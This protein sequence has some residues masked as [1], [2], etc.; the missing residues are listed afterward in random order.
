MNTTTVDTQVIVAGSGGRSTPVKLTLQ[1]GTERVTVEMKVVTTRAVTTHGVTHTPFRPE[2]TQFWAFSAD[3]ITLSL[4]PDE[5]R[6]CSKSDKMGLNPDRSVGSIGQRQEISDKV[7][8]QY[9]YFWFE[10]PASLDGYAVTLK[11]TEHPYGGTG[12]IDAAVSATGTPSATAVTV[13]APPTA[14]VDGSGTITAGATSQVVFAANANRRYLF[15]LND[16][17]TDAW[18]NFG[19]AAVASQ[20][21]IKIPANGGFFEP[22]VVSNQSVNI[23]GATTGKTFVAKQG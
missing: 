13:Q 20:P 19:T 10:Y 17:D 2:F 15:L 12:A 11:V 9:G 21:S 3:D 7:R 5:L 8:G 4:V 6:Y 1:T 16:S 14:Y 22:L 23:I 18:V